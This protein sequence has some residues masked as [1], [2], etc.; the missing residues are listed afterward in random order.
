MPAGP[1]KA[2]TCV[3]RHLLTRTGTKR[4]HSVA[5]VA[6]VTLISLGTCTGTDSNSRPDVVRQVIRLSLKQMQKSNHLINSTD[7]V[8]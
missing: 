2:R 8:R 6:L 4:P 1:A 7:P 5:L 3:P